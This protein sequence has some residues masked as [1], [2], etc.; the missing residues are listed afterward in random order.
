MLLGHAVLYIHLIRPYRGCFLF[1]GLCTRTNCNRFT[2]IHAYMYYRMYTHSKPNEYRQWVTLTASSIPS[3]LNLHTIIRRRLAS[4]FFYKLS[5]LSFLLFGP[6]SP[7]V[8]L[9]PPQSLLQYFPP[10]LGAA[11]SV[12]PA[13]V[14]LEHVCVC[15]LVC[16][17]AVFLV[18]FR[19]CYCV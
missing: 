18:S 3:L 16:F 7:F 4:H 9:F 2:H 1:V 15:L 10:L 8:F 13:S 19:H 11:S 14:H 12:Q 6:V 5:L 17:I